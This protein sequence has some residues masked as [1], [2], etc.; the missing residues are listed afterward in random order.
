MRI[1]TDCPH[2][3]KLIFQLEPYV[4][5]GTLRDRTSPVDLIFQQ[6]LI[7]GTFCIPLS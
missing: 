5:S 3:S 4:A 2:N 6:R 7:E 1:S